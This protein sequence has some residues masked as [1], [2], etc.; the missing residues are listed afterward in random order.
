MRRAPRPRSRAVGALVD[1]VAVN[2]SARKARAAAISL[3]ALALG[4][5]ASAPA[6]SPDSSDWGYYGGD[7]FGQRFSS[8]DQINRSN[9]KR[10]QVAWIY[11]TGELGAG[12]AQARRLTFEAT[13]VLAFGRLYLETGT[14]IVIALDPVSG[15]ELWRYDPRTDRARRYAEYTSRGV[16]IWASSDPRRTGPCVR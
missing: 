15:R 4:T 9:V 6:Q 16:S 7:M 11:R 5:T 1:N 13:P 14:N 10:L 2:H 12:S 8:L 3:V